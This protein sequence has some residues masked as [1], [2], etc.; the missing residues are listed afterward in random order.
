MPAARLVE[1]RIITVLFADLVGFT[2]LSEQLDAEDVALV[3]DAYSLDWSLNLDHDG[4]VAGV[5]LPSR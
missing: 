4:C 3:Q 1:R 2:A 5:R